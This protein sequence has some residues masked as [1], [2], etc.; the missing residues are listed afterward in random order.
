MIRVLVV[1]DSPMVVEIVR[2]ILE[3][4]P[5][6]RVIAVARNGSEAVALARTLKPDLITMDIRMPVLDGISATQAIMEEAP[7]PILVLAGSVNEDTSL[8]FRAIQAGAVDVVEKPVAPMMDAYAGLE[9]VQRARLVASVPTIRRLRRRGPVEAVADEGVKGLVGIVAS[10]G[11]PPALAAVLGGLP[12]DFHSPVLVVQHI[13]HGFLQ[14]LVDWLGQQVPM[15]VRIAERGDIARPG[16]AYFAPEDSHLAIGP[17]GSLRLLKDPPVDGHRPSG[18]VLLSSMAE[19]CPAVSVGVVL[20]GMGR[21]GAEGLRALREAGGHALAQDEAT[22]LIYGM[23]KAAVELGAVE[24]VV[25][26]ELVAREIV[27]ALRG[28]K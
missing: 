13:A 22:S 16:T 18:T 7:T 17:N 15:P 8:A 24:R 3:G 28:R 1:D 25:P 27:T 9:L 5:G 2:T 23:P 12:A 6:F 26:L 11:G 21:D 4:D 20:T 14:G 10:T 19:T